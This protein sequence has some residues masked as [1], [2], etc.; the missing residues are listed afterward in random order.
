MTLINPII[1][2]GKIDY[3]RF[4]L[5]GLYD[6]ASRLEVFCKKG[7]P[8]NSEKFTGKYPCQRLF[9]KNTFYCRTPPVA[10]S[11]MNHFISHS[12]CLKRM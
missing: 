7:V 6:G 9:F 12:L 8:E 11:D 2:I 10:A 5:L 3:L 1:V 4:L